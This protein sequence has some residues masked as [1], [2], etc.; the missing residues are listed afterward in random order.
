MVV[1][2]SFLL[3]YPS[4]CRSWLLPAR[5]FQRSSPLTESLEQGIKPL[6]MNAN[7]KKPN[8]RK[9]KMISLS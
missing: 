2:L 5:V 6:T 1:A 9:E 4:H 8:H 7:K 3:L